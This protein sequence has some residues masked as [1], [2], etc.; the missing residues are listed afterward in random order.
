[1]RARSVM[2]FMSEVAIGAI[3]AGVLVAILIWLTPDKTVHKG[4]IDRVDYEYN[5]H[6][7]IDRIHGKEY[8]YVDGELIDRF[9]ISGDAGD[10]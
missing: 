4:R 3:A 1:M 10:M 2:K 9:D 8:L 7:I 6:V 5:T